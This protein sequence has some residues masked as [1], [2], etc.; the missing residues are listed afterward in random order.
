M[1]NIFFITL[2][3]LFDFVIENMLNPK[4]YFMK[5]KKINLYMHQL[6]TFNLLCLI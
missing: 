3:L 4:Y 5:L 1:L 6:I 2:F